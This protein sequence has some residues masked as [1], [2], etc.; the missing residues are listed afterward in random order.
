VGGGGASTVEG[1]VEVNAD[2][3]A[4]MFKGAVHHGALSPWNTSVGN[5]NVQTAIEIL[6]NGVDGLLDLLR[7]GDLNLI[8]FGYGGEIVR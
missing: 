4:V 3:I 6:H 5:K 7:I 1:T 2:N 8:G